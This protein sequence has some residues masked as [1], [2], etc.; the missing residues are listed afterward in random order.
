MLGPSPRVYED[1]YKDVEPKRRCSHSQHL[2]HLARMVGKATRSLE[3]PVRHGLAPAVEHKFTMVAPLGDSHVG[4]LTSSYNVEVWQ[5]R[6]AVWEHAV[7]E[8]LHEHQPERLIVPLLGDI[9]DGESIYP[10]HVFNLEMSVVRQYVTASTCI[11]QTLNRISTLI[12]VEV[13]SVAGNHG[14]N[15]RK[16]ESP[17]LTNWDHVMYL[18]MDALL[19]N[20]P[21]VSVRIIEDWYTT[22]PV[23]DRILFITHGAAIRG[24]GSMNSLANS[25]LKW[26]VSLPEVWTDGL[27]GHF[28]C[29]HSIGIGPGSLYVNGSFV[30]GDKFAERDLKKMSSPSQKVLMFSTCRCPLVTDI[31]L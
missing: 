26:Q 18:H 27:I 29:P 1:G 31:Q 19:L 13:P 8:L 14:R 30:S 25:A 28:H 15:G 21:A 4:K 17:D 6:L 23:Y 2:R 5:E 24:E 9:V 22:V 12:D 3:P 16:G 20:N 11:A 7:T 10:G